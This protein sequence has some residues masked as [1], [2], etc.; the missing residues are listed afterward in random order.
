L[1]DGSFISA[2][3]VS[4]SVGQGGTGL[5]PVGVTERGK[6][7][8]KKIEKKFPR[9]QPSVWEARKSLCFSL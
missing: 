3:A 5:L 6:T 7:G 4:Q 8:E 2:T 1:S 9:H